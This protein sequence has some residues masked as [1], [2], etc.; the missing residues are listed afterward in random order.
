MVRT[1]SSPDLD[2]LTRDFGLSLEGLPVDVVA[3]LAR[4][5]E[6]L[7]EARAMADRDPLVPVLNRRAFLRETQRAVSFVER[8]HREAAVLFVDLDHFKLVNDTFGHA[9][10]DAVLHHVARLLIENV[11]ESDCVGRLGGDEFGVILAETGKDEAHAKARF[12]RDLLSASPAHH[13]GRAHAISAT[14]GV[15]MI[16]PLD[17]AETAIARAD[18]AMYAAKPPVR[19]KVA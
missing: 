15:H 17:D 11:R 4:M 16:T 18:E 8:Y 6:A 7:Q 19:P 1:D 14:I 3:G 12:L 5:A 9:A 10:G 2:A 13:Q